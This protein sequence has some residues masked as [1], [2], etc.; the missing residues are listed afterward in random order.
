MQGVEPEGQLSVGWEGPAPEHGGPTLDRAAAY[1]TALAETLATA[2]YHARYLSVGLR[3]E[4]PDLLR[5]TVR[6]DVP[7][8]SARDFESI[9]RVT[10][11]GVGAEV[12]LTHE[13][14][15]LLGAQLVSP[16]APGHAPVER[17]VPW[18]K[19]ALAL[20]V[21]LLLG[22]IGLPR[23]DLFRPPRPT[24]V[25]LP[26]QAPTPVVLPT[27]TSP[28][29]PTSLPAVL[30]PTVAAPRLVFGEGFAAPLPNWPNDPNATAWFADG[31][32]RLFA[33]LPGKF[34][35][36][37]VPLPAPLGDATL[38][39]QFH[40]IAGPTGGGY[41]LI[42]RDQGAATAHDGLN[43][44]G[45]YMVLEIGDRG[46]VGIWQRDQTRWIDVVPWTRS[47]AVHMDRDPNALTVTTRGTSLRFE[48]NGIGVAEVSYTGLPSIGGVGVFVGGDLNDVALEWLRITTP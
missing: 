13:G 46:D 47:N 31:Q 8:I 23:L 18:A 24:P 27:P 14:D 35:A 11:N 36:T 34:V 44:G 9:A 4:R 39:A 43:Q 22:V 41:G 2:G 5:L 15:L 32:Y 45:E 16:P 20:A 33:R 26:R 10:L 25:V 29:S 6:G 17:R 37:G 48:V 1:V 21:G 40:K 38:S 28:T 3:R 7:G 12:G 42:V 30:A 19:I